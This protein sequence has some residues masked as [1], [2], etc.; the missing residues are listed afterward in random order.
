MPFVAVDHWD[1][2][3]HGNDPVEYAVEK[4]KNALDNTLFDIRT[5]QPIPFTPLNGTNF[6]TEYAHLDPDHPERA[7]SLA[8]RRVDAVG[9]SY[10]GVITR[11]YITPKGEA[12]NSSPSWYK[13]S[14]NIA[15]RPTPAYGGDI[16]KFVTLGSMWRGVPLVN[17]A[18]EG[19]FGDMQA[20]RSENGLRLWDAPVPLPFPVP[21]RELLPI[22]A[23]NDFHT[24]VPAM[25]VMAIN[26]K[27]LSYLLFQSPSPDAST[28]PV[29]NP[30]DDEIAYGSVAGDDNY[31]PISGPLGLDP[32][33]A[34]GYNQVPS[35][36]PFLGLETR[37]FN[38]DRHYPTDG[39]V[40]LWS[41]AIPGDYPAHFVAPTSHNG[42]PANQQTQEYLARWLNNAG[43]PTGKQLKEQWNGSVSMADNFLTWNFE[44]GKMAPYPQNDLYVQTADGIGRLNPQAFSNPYTVRLNFAITLARAQSGQIVATLRVTNTNPHMVMVPDLRIADMTL[45]AKQAS[46]N[47]TPIRLFTLRQGESSKPVTAYFAGNVGA[48][49]TSASLKIN[50]TYTLGS[51]TVT[52][53]NLQLP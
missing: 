44:P 35:W 38:L 3:F 7:T 31:Y 43:L 29:A 23:E 46:A 28:Q 4:L 19:N 27:W 5:G 25:E 9:W 22:L 53:R 42:Y 11:W 15:L 40:P 33:N 14:Y 2:V 51:G 45:T 39:L 34:I 24:D 12:A 36:F 17:Y 37:S 20:T 48:S 21:L 16:R 1:S 18:N 13:R 8:I 32:Y 30:F 52:I 49:G 47:L 10:G 50:F 6:F 26:S 41:A